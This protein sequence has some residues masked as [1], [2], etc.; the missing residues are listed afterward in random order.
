MRLRKENQQQN[1]DGTSLQVTQVDVGGPLLVL[2]IYQWLHM[3]SLMLEKYLSMLLIFFCIDRYHYSSCTWWE[4]SCILWFGESLDK[5][6]ALKGLKLGES[7]N[8]HF[9]ITTSI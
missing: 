3:V 8:T 1:R 7:Y 4:C 5:G 2:S 9:F 6:E